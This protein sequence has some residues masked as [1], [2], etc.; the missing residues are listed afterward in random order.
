MFLY[1]KFVR[2]LAK[3]KVMAARRE[4]H[5]LNAAHLCLDTRADVSQINLYG[6]LTPRIQKLLHESKKFKDANNYKYCWAKNGSV[7]LRKT[8][9]STPVRLRSL[10]DLE[11]FAVP[12]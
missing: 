4:V 10:E 12:R 9:S 3:D 11:G 5:S 7:Y 1:C 2:R 8:D 6:H